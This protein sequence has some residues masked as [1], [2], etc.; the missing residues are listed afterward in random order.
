MAFCYKNIE[1]SSFFHSSF[2]LVS[3]SWMHDWGIESMPI[4][5]AIIYPGPANNKANKNS[6][7]NEIGYVNGH[8]YRWLIIWKWIQSHCLEQKGKW[9]EEQQRQQYVNK[10]GHEFCYKS[11]KCQF[12]TVSDIK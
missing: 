10:R 3:I 9:N 11:L 12:K 8:Q 4:L 1:Y 5:Y 7:N 6:N 2:A